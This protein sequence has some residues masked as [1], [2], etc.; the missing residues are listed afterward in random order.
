MSSSLSDK[1]YSGTVAYGKVQAIMG[2]VVGTV[3]SIVL[4]ITGLVLVKRKAKLTDTINAVIVSDPFCNQYA[5][6]S[7][8][9]F[10]CNN[11]SL[12]YTVNNKEYTLNTSTDSTIKYTK[13]LNV[14]IYYDPANPSYASMTSDNVKPLGWIFFG[15]GT[16]MLVSAWTWV[17]LTQKYH[18]AAA[19]GGIASVINTV[20]R[21]F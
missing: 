20:K 14:N 6:S 5:D 10:R 4:I 16:L 19:T 17:F 21:A 1:L 12:K 9:K 3:V 11:I 18:V 15:F 8:V 13:G 7:L 2:A